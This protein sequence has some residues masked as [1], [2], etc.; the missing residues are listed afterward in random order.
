[1]SRRAR[2]TT[3]GRRRC[4]RSLGSVDAPLTDLTDSS[5]VR[6]IEDNLFAFW[7]S[8]R[9]SPPF[10]VEDT[11]EFVRYVSGISFPLLNGILRAKL[12]PVDDVISAA[13]EPIRSRGLPMMWWTGPSST[14]E[15]IGERLQRLG[16]V[17][18]DTSIGMAVDLTT[19]SE[20]PETA[21]GLLITPVKS[22]DDMAAMMSVLAGSFGLP[23]FVLEAFSRLLS[24]I[25][26]NDT[27]PVTSFVGRL[28]G[29]PVACSSAAFFAG[30]A[31]V[32]NVGVLPEVRRAKLGRAI[33]L[34]SLL[35]GKRRGYRAGILQSSEMGLRVYERLG[36]RT[37]C[38]L[39]QHIWLPA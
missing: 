18:G 16:L 14:P 39:R 12:P 30:V 4:Q 21:P 36:F 8:V 26:L 19:L 37:Y 22:A 3:S 38:T 35:E 5:L 25:G 6:A 15:D 9:I 31:G 1:M 34:A 32:Y 28:D 13:M 24:D 27:S 33:T 29:K 11:P 2:G 10:V 17:G 20:E 23:D 7:S